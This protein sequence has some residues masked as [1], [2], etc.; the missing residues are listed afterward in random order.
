MYES[1]DDRRPSGNK[2]L[3]MNTG[4]KEVTK[5]NIYANGIV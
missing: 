1:V 2:F 3:K 5:M 4:Y